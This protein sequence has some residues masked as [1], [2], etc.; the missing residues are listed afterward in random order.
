ME[1]GPK[2]GLP[3]LMV[4]IKAHRSTDGE[5]YEFILEIPNRPAGPRRIPF[6]QPPVFSIYH[7]EPS[8]EGYDIEEKSAALFT[9][10]IPEEWQ[11]KGIGSELIGIMKK[12]A[13]SKG[14]ERFYVHEVKPESKG[15]FVK[16]GFEPDPHHPEWWKMKEF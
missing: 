14:A 8:T 6:M 12:F 3:G 10:Y 5:D 7:T 13:K 15:F 11:R 16:T 1:I 4:R 2:I 9:I